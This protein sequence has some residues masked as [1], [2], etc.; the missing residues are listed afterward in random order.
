M[1]KFIFIGVIFAVVFSL[2]SAPSQAAPTKVDKPV[3]APTD[4]SAYVGAITSEMAVF[5][6]ECGE[7]KRWTSYHWNDGTLG[8]DEW[9]FQFDLHYD[10][11]KTQGD[12]SDFWYTVSEFGIGKYNFEGLEQDCDTRIGAHKM[13][14]VSFN[15]YTWTP[16]NGRNFNPP[17]FK[18]ACAKDTTNSKLQEYQ[19]F[20]ATPPKLWF[21]SG[22]AP[23]FKVL[24][25]LHRTGVIF[26]DV[27]DSG[28]M[29]GRMRKCGGYAN[30]KCK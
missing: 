3:A 28:L 12:K 13:K 14:Y 7:R 23:Y 20:G 8:A 22:E 2:F 4:M 1:K 30:N 5:N 9:H 25:N 27:S 24:W 10:F 6:L 26:P 21:H 17:A 29:H 19:A 11:C 16:Y 18:V 15:L